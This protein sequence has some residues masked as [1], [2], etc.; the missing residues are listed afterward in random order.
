MFLDSFFMDGWLAFFRVAL[1]LLDRF[2]HELM[3]N[4]DIGYVAQFFHTLRGRTEMMDIHMLLNDGIRNFQGL[5]DEH[6]DLLES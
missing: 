4:S 1:S 2:K 3:A 5:N 6:I